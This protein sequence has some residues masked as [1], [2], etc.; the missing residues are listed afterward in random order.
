MQSCEVEKIGLEELISRE[1]RR[2]GKRMGKD[3]TRWR[4]Y[5]TLKERRAQ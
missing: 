3:E 1:E 4:I 5:Q 2:Y